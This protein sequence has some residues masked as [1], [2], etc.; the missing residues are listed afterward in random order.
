[1]SLSC[2]SIKQVR[3]CVGQCPAK[4]LHRCMDG[5]KLW[6]ISSIRVLALLGRSRQCH[7]DGWWSAASACCSLQSS[8]LFVCC[9]LS[10]TTKPRYQNDN[11][12]NYCHFI[13]LVALFFISFAD[14]AEQEA[15]REGGFVNSRC[16]PTNVCRYASWRRRAHS[17]S[18][19]HHGEN[20]FKP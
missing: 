9:C 3:A 18:G 2:L 11:F 14:G 8:V 20:R 16:K 10:S 5:S 17:I 4:K 1:M 13:S 7:N 15:W 6:C 19:I 12:F